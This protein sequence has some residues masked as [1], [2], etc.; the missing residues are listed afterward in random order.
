MDIYTNAGSQLFR[1]KIENNVVEDIDYKE[2]KL[3]KLLGINE[4]TSQ[5]VCLSNSTETDLHIYHFDDNLPLS[6]IFIEDS[7]SLSDNTPINLR[8]WLLK[9]EN[10][11]IFLAK[12]D[13][14]SRAVL[15]EN[16]QIIENISSN[17][18]VS[19]SNVDFYQGIPIAFGLNR[20]TIL[21]Q[22]KSYT[23]N[24]LF[25]STGNLT[26]LFYFISKSN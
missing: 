11:K 8:D 19:I 18:N 25:V 14:K 16:N 22:N 5:I 15:L 13:G 23:F 4:Q 3:H 21:S 20:S 12:T 10:N 26:N 17:I 9:I 6:T 7:L 2:I 24:F 1:V